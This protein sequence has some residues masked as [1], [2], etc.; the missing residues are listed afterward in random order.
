MWLPRGRGR[1]GDGLRIWG[2]YIQMIAF[3]MGKQCDPAVEP[4]NYNSS[5]MMEH[6]NVRKK[7]YT[8]MCDW[9]TLLYSGKLTGCCQ[10]AIMEKIKIIKKTKIK[11]NKT[12]KQG[13]GIWLL[14][15]FFPP[16]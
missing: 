6:D 2:S 13:A 14:N 4:G 8:C 7:N 11:N 9:V 16:P 1:E 15:D 10:P 12:A 5:L 3:R